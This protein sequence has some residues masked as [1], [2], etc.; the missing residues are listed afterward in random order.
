VARPVAR[1]AAPPATVDGVQELLA[2]LRAATERHPE[3]ETLVAALARVSELPGNGHPE[4]GHPEHDGNDSGNGSV[5]LTG[6]EHGPDDATNG[7]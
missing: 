3:D 2:A 5:A 6:A 7:R 4:N 1:V